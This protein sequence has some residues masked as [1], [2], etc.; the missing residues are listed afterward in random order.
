MMAVRKFSGWKEADTSEISNL[1]IFFR[2]QL[3]KVSA[4]HIFLFY[5]EV[6]AGKTES[7]KAMARIWGMK[8]IASPS[9]AIHHAYTS[10]AHR[11]DHVDLYRLEN[12]E[13]LEGTGFWDLFTQEQALVVIEWPER[14]NTDWLPL[15]WM[16][17]EF[18]F[19]ADFTKTP[20]QRKIKYR[21][22]S[23]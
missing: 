12:E 21:Q 9:F 16:I 13:E 20:A 19:S 15:N 11:I 18:Y 10:S 2:S 3:A 22:Q 17:S 23:E 4:K 1:E 5:G 8:D 7:V 6:G 14:L